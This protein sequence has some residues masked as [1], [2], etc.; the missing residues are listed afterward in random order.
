MTSTQ[1][2][3]AYPVVLTFGNISQNEVFVTFHEPNFFEN[4]WDSLVMRI[5]ATTFWLIALCGSII[6]FAYVYYE[7][8]GYA[9]SFRTV[10]NQ[11]VTWCYFYVSLYSTSHIVWKSLKSTFQIAVF[12]TIAGVINLT[13][14]WIGP[15]PAF[16]CYLNLL[17]KGGIANGFLFLML[18]IFVMK[19]L[20]IC[21]WKRLRPIDDDFVARITVLS[22]VF[23]GFGV[24]FSKL[25]GPGRYPNNFV[26]I[27]GVS[28]SRKRSLIQHSRLFVLVHSVQLKML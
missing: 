13:R 15:L 22:A 25:I 6:I 17:L 23:W 20:F 10:I 26:S 28:K 3:Y 11:L 4:P 14:A 8:Q 9:A 27:H 16:I 12:Q 21:K 2:V 18:G 5:T 1:F 7:T 24:Q 19:Y